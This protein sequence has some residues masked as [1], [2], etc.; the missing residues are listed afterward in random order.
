MSE[1]RCPECGYPNVTA[2]ANLR[3]LVTSLKKEAQDYEHKNNPT[4]L[5]KGMM[6]ALYYS[7]NQLESEVDK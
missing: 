5:E 7:A 1:I 4:E 6:Y 3:D 2:D